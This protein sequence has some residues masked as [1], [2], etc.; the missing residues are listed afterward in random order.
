MNFDDLTVGQAKELRAMFGDSGGG[1]EPFTLPIGSKVVLR[2]VTMIYTGT[3]VSVGN[4]ELV[5]EDASWVADTRRWADFLKNGVAAAG[6]EIEP[7]PEGKVSV[8]RG[9]LV[10]ACA[11]NHD[12]PRK[13]L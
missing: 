5:L 3:L 6:I 2:T 4:R 11:W 10:D 9:A 1:V 12:L 13:Q 8:G 7:Y